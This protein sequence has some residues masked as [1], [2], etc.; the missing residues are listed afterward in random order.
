MGILLV[1][2][3]IGAVGYHWLDGQSWVDAVLNSVMIMTGVGLEKELTNDASKNFTSLYALV[4]TIIYFFVL[5][6]IFAP[7]IHRFLHRF[8]LDLEDQQEN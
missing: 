5:G 4:S 2:L 1:A 8:H 7:L 6:I 3:F